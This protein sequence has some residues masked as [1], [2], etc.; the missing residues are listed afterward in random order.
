MKTRF[1]VS[2]AAEM[3]FFMLKRCVSCVERQDKDRD[4]KKWLSR[5]ISR[6]FAVLHHF[7]CDCTASMLPSVPQVRCKVG[8]SNTRC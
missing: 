3:D 2:V 8:L 7:G 6:C 1:S 4:G 5:I